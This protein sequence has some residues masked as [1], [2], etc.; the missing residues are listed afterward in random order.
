[1]R[2]ARWLLVACVVVLGATACRQLLG[3]DDLP[4]HRDGGPGSPAMHDGDSG[5]ASGVDALGSDGGSGSNGACDSS[6]CAAHAGSCVAGVCT[7]NPTGSPAFCP[8]GMPCKIICGA[9]GPTLDCSAATSCTID[10]AWDNSCSGKTIK[11]GG[12][13][14]ILC[15]GNSTCSD[16]T[17][18]S[19]GPSCAFECCGTGACALD[20]AVC[21]Q[22]VPGSCP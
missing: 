20:Q 9:C 11:C 5:S 10:C 8:P 7:I 15:R 1:M 13:C 22:H 17:V 16:D 2:T 19:A 12:N 3:L 18:T 6:I 4:V 14:E 21:A